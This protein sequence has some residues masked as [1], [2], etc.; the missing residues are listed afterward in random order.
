M[1]INLAEMDEK[2]LKEFR[3]LL[4][5]YYRG[6]IYDDESLQKYVEE[7]K[8]VLVLTDNDRDKKIL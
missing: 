2:Q 3:E 1:F 6:L 8:K 4:K 5:I 7:R